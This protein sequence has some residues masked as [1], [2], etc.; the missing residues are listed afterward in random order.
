MENLMGGLFSGSGD[1]AN[2]VVSAGDNKSRK[3]KR[4][5]DSLSLNLFTDFLDYVQ[6][7]SASAEKKTVMFGS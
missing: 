1:G 2:L 4:K 3:R 6:K 5:Q 7:E